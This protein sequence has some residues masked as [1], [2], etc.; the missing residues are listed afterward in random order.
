MQSHQLALSPNAAMMRPQVVIVLIIS[1]VVAYSF[2]WWSGGGGGN[3]RALPG[4]RT[5]AERVGTRS[6]FE[7]ADAIHTIAADEFPS[8]AQVDDARATQHDALESGTVWRYPAS[9][10]R[11]HFTWTGGGVRGYSEAEVNVFLDAWH[12]RLRKNLSDLGIHV[13]RD[14]WQR[15]GRRDTGRTPPTTTGRL[16]AEEYGAAALTITGNADCLRPMRPSDL[17]LCHAWAA[18]TDPAGEK[19]FNSAEQTLFH[20][21]TLASMCAHTMSCGV[22]GRGRYSTRLNASFLEGIF[23]SVAADQAAVRQ[24]AP[25]VLNMV[26]SGFSSEEYRWLER[27]MHLAE[28]RKQKHLV[29]L[30]QW[31]AKV[32][33]AYGV[34]LD[35]RP[36]HQGGAMWLNTTSQEDVATPQY[37]VEGPPAAS[38]RALDGAPAW[39]SAVTTFSASE[40]LAILYHRATSRSRN[41]ERAVFRDRSGSGSGSI[42]SDGA[43]CSAPA[44]NMI[45]VTGDSIAYQLFRRLLRLMRNGA[46]TP[47]TIQV[48][49]TQLRTPLRARPNFNFAK[50]HDMVLA[51]YPTHDELRLFRSLV[52]QDRRHARKAS[53]LATTNEFFQGI[54][55]R[56]WSDFC[57]SGEARSPSAVPRQDINTEEPKLSGDDEPHSVGDRQDALFYLVYLWDPLTARPRSDALVPCTGLIARER[58]FRPKDWFEGYA[59]MAT[60]T[61]VYR[62]P[63]VPVVPLRDL[64]ARIGLHI[65]GAN[66]WEMRTSSVHQEVLLRM[67]GQ[68]GG[69]A[70]GEGGEPRS[71]D[72][73]G[74]SNTHRPAAVSGDDTHL[75]R[76]TP[77]LMVPHGPAQ[78]FTHV[79]AS[80]DG[81]GQAEPPRS[82]TNSTD[83]VD[84]AR[85]GN[86]APTSVGS[87]AAIAERSL[88]YQRNI[89]I[90]ASRFLRTAEVGRTRE[91]FEWLSNAT[92]RTENKSIDENWTPTTSTERQQ[93]SRSPARLG[94]R[95]FSL[96]RILDIQKAFLILSKN[97]GTVAFEN[98]GLHESCNGRLPWLGVLLGDDDGS[99]SN[100]LR[101]DRN[102]R[103][104]EAAI[105][106]VAKYIDKGRGYSSF[107]GP[108]YFTPAFRGVDGCGDFGTLLTATAL[109]ADIVAGGG[110]KGG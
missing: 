15:R 44:I 108:S 91:L 6:D 40:A 65:E 69:C 76:L 17:L 72:V 56:R 55:Q 29:W 110:A 34:P 100:G 4:D 60:P 87:I 67:A 97:N 89:N 9:A 45:V 86:S 103:R 7:S 61:T 80:V 85:N 46:A 95:Y 2:G 22:W 101:R 18:S 24:R 53:S 23:R 51:V 73:A 71:G 106:P 64:G 104:L 63:D 78:L 93:Q 96:V 37:V 11:E 1:T 70:T 35:V 83:D 74:G 88:R 36:F 90:T 41:G 49:G 39:S 94:R 58:R 109:L 10:A 77:V 62:S 98:D 3:V 30:A 31:F 107:Y 28:S 16:V 12:M 13:H 42:L 54:A 38:R 27:R 25:L 92:P 47:V 75:Y 99:T 48:G 105:A 33:R 43:P 102:L 82:S 19:G 52:F 50:W 81:A 84:E 79:A 5:P 21:H 68:L 66:Q 14:T 8:R 32:D 57:A 59:H 20:G 26:H